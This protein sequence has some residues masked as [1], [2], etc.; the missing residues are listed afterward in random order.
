MINVLTVCFYQHSSIFRIKFVPSDTVH[1]DHESQVQIEGTGQ[2][3]QVPP[4]VAR[5]LY[6][7]VQDY[8]KI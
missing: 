7:S 5:T 4:T 6:P 8:D 3:Q 1:F 2:P